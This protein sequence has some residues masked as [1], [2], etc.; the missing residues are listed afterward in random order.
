MNV[1]LERARREFDILS[2]VDVPVLARSGPLGLDTINVDGK[3]WLYFTEEWVDGRTMR[4]LIMEGALSPEQIVKLGTDLI[5]A[6]CWLSER[7]L[8]HRDIKPANVMFDAQ[9]SRYILIDPGVALDLEAPSLTQFPLPVGTFRY[10]SPEQIEPSKRRALDFRSDLFSI[11]IVMYEAATG[12]HP[13]SQQSATISE[14]LSGILHTDPTPVSDIV[15]GFPPP[16]SNFIMRLL[17]KSA[18]QRFRTCQ[19]AFLNINEIGR[20]LGV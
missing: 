3:I 18:H 2:Q 6:V 5:Q 19:R 1:P 20:S 4:D 14:A 7:N 16:L 17:G 11:G 9:N 15:E 8:V 12:Q 10:F 13:L